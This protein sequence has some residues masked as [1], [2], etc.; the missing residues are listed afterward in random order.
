M[1]YEV[2]THKMPLTFEVEVER[3]DDEE[4]DRRYQTY[5][6]RLT[7]CRVYASSKAKALRKIRQAIDI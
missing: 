6:G 3:N 2:T 4:E 1:A 5:C 7:G